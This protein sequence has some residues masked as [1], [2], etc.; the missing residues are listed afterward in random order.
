MFSAR[1][2]GCRRRAAASQNAGHS[3]DQNDSRDAALHSSEKIEHV[4]AVTKQQPL[5]KYGLG[6]DKDELRIHI[7]FALSR[8]A[9]PGLRSLLPIETSLKFQTSAGTTRLAFFTAMSKRFWSD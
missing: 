1:L 8:S 3:S 2:G 5:Q 6:Y 4:V 9:T 7:A